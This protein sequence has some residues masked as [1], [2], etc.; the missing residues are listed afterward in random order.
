[1]GN[2]TLLYGKGVKYYVG[3]VLLGRNYQRVT[4]IPLLFVS[5]Q[6]TSKEEGRNLLYKQLNN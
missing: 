4:D 5:C 6:L 3:S 2:V 1:M